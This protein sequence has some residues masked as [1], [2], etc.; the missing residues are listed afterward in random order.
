MSGEWHIQVLQIQ[1]TCTHGYLVLGEQTNPSTKGGDVFVEAPD[2]L[3][4]LQLEMTPVKAPEQM[5]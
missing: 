3:L 2:T 1:L 5:E 4:N